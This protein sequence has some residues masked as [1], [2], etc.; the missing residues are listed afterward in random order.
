[1]NKDTNQE[2]VLTG[3]EAEALK[4]QIRTCSITLLSVKRTSIPYED[5]GHFSSGK[6]RGRC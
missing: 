5:G 3:V 2:G 4:E 1:M 6:N